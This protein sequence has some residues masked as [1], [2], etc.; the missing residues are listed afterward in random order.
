MKSI[1][2]DENY[3]K[4]LIPSK[5]LLQVEDDSNLKYNNLMKTNK[6]SKVFLVSM[7]IQL[8]LI[9]AIQMTIRHNIQYEVLYFG[10]R[11]FDLILLVPLLINIRRLYIENVSRNIAFILCELMIA[12][13]FVQI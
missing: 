6:E 11:M 5:I 9:S 7:M 10:L 8:I 1:Q 4:A 3:D 13:G 12:S 2:E